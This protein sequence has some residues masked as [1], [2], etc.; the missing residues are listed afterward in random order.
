MALVFF[1][2]GLLV[3]FIV[4]L[5]VGP[6]ALVC[7][8]RSLA[9][10]RISGICSG[11]GAATAD[12]VYSAVAGLGVTFISSF[13]MSHQ[14]ALRLTGGAVLILL[15]LHIALSKP[16]N[17][18]GDLSDTSLIGDYVSTFFLTLTNPLTILA[19][20]AGFASLGMEGAPRKHLVPLVLVLGVFTGSALWW[21]LLGTIVGWCR[22]WIT[23]NKLR[24]I[25]K[26]SGA[27]ISL[28]G[29]TVFLSTGTIILFELFWL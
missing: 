27:A 19:F 4:A 18:E 22:H 13:L 14:M 8:G 28:F 3:G 2:K 12:G 7:I 21:V 25:N 26:V 5:P 11:I 9:K 29:L 16:P 10:G 6:V 1:F 23:P 17:R 24:L 20:A 15:G